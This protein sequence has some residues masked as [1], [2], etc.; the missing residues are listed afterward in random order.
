MS[1]DL[2]KVLQ[3]FREYQARVFIHL[4]SGGIMCFAIL[5]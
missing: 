2:P 5:S 3:T 4:A 1:Y